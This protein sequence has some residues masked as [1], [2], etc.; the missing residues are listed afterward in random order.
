MIQTERVNGGPPFRELYLITA[1]AKE[2]LDLAS[3]Y[4]DLTEELGSIIAR[5]PKGAGLAN[6]GGNR[7]GR[8]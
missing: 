8:R 6:E 2:E 7:G 4:P 3:V 1:D 5:F